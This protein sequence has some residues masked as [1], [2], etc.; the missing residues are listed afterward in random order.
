MRTMQRFGRVLVAVVALVFVVETRV[1][2][3][4]YMKLDSPGLAFP[5]GYPEAKRERISAVLGSKKCKF[6][7]GHALNSFTTLIYQGNTRALNLFLDGLAKC[8]GLTIHVSF[9]KPTNSGHGLS[10]NDWS[11]HHHAGEA[12]RFHVR[13]NLASQQIDLE[14]LYLPDIRTAAE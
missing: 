10:G 3:A 5:A 4:I 6:V 14:K 7:G 9:C 12:N 13:I 8:R 2:H 11:V 1:A